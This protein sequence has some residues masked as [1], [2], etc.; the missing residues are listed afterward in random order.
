MPF[1]LNGG[2]SGEVL[3][4]KINR[5]VLKC[6]RYATAIDARWSF[7]LDV[8]QALSI[9]YDLPAGLCSCLKSRRLSAFNL[10]GCL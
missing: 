9:G 5:H 6:A 7:C 8:F 4:L 1:L 3:R 2:F 10:E